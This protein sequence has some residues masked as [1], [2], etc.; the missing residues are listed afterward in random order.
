LQSDAAAWALAVLPV[1]LVLA[2]MGC[3]SRPPGR[4]VVDRV[5]IERVTIPGVDVE[6]ADRGVS[7]SAIEEKIATAASGRRSRYA[8]ATRVRPRG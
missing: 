7:D 2:T 5:D 6:D 4:Y 3:A 1:V 8:S